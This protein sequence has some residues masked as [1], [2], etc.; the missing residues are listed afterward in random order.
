MIANSIISILKGTLLTEYIT[1]SWIFS[2][3]IISDF[4]VASGEN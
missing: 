4:D 2:H 3:E 1:E